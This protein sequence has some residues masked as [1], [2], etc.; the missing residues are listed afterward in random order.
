MRSTVRRR[1]PVYFCAFDLL[2]LEGTDLRDRPLLERKRRL[3]R[4]VPR[5]SDRL[6]YVKH[7]RG[8]G[9]D[10][11]RLACE[12]DLEGVVAK[13]APS[14]YRLAGQGLALGE[15]SR[16]RTTARRE[17]ATSCS[18]ASDNARPGDRQSRGGRSSRQQRQ[19]RRTVERLKRASQVQQ[20]VEGAGALG[21][22]KIIR[23]AAEERHGP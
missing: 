11:F 4:I 3:R 18:R 12:Q 16:T 23:Q 22:L 20:R 1:V 7:V 2:A 9:V 15:R 5:T 14:A 19:P 21:V 8:R 10:L 6:R 13:L 17:I